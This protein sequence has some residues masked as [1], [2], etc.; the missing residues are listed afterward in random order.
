MAL[1]FLLYF[2]VRANVIDRPELALANA[3]QSSTSSGR[4]GSSASRPGSSA[5][6]DSAACWSVLQLRLLLARLPADRGARAVHVLAGGAAVHLHPRRDPVLRRAG[7]VAYNLCPVAPP[8]LLPEIGRH[9]HAAG[10]QQ[11]QLPGA[12]DRSSSST[13][14]RRCPACTSA[15][16]SCWRSACCWRFRRN[17]LVLAAGACCTRWRSAPRRSSPATTTSSTA[18][19][20]WWRPRRGLAFAWRCSAGATR[21]PEAL[22]H[23]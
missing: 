15:G 17:R 2:V 21:W 10:V 14:T 19:A 16:R 1:A 5:I 18:P 12:V 7:A 23:A 3:R 13:R 9:R 6:L 8:R 20:G 4:W 22:W 11:P